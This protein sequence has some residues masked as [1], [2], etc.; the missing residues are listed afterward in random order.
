MSIPSSDLPPGESLRALK[1]QARGDLV[2]ILQQA[3]CSLLVSTYQAG[4]VAVVGVSQGQLHLTLHAFPMAMGL[5]LGPQGLAIGTRN[6][7]WF[8]QNVPEMAANLS[9]AGAYDGCFLARRSHFTGQ[10]HC[11]ELA[12]LGGELWVANTLFSCL[13]TIDENYSFV[14]RWQPPFIH[15]LSAN[16]RCHLNGLATLDG[17]VAMVSVLGETGQPEGWRGNKV[18]GGAVLDVAT[19][20]AIVRGLCMPHSPRL[21]A[22]HAFVLNSG[23]GQLATFDPR[24]G[25]M[26]TVESMPGYT[27][28]LSFHGELAFVGLSKIRESNV[29]GGLPIAQS[30]EPLRCGVAVVDWRRGRTLAALEFQSGFD[31]IF[32]VQVVPNMHCPALSG[33]DYVS[34][35][36]QATWLI[37]P[38][39]R[40]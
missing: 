19:G 6:Q 36:H 20:Q 2:G 35:G 11:H 17:R 32:A 13:A 27:R 1:Y 5:A 23:R 33:P 18:S 14:P 9:P 30:A 28:G 24:S 34:D 40:I 10:I 12:W 26:E 7:I 38:T 39:R 4:R 31:E 15:E 8:L 25:Q 22:G 3:N 29:F 16:D 21:H 37:S